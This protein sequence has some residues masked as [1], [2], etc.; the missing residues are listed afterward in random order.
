MKGKSINLSIF[1]TYFGIINQFQN[2]EN[3]PKSNTCV[4]KVKNRPIGAG[5]KI[6]CCE[7]LLPNFGE[8]CLFFSKKIL[9]SLAQYQVLVSV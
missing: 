5:M 4:A 2:M 9:E 3:S 7:K 6:A 1:T 8:Y